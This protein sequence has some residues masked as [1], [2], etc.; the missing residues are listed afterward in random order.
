MTDAF[1]YDNMYSYEQRTRKKKKMSKEKMKKMKMKK[2][3]WDFE[4]MLLCEITKEEGVV[5]RV[6]FSIDKSERDKF[7]HLNNTDK[8][9]VKVLDGM[10]VE[11]AKKQTTDFKQHPFFMSKPNKKG[12]MSMSDKGFKQW[13]DYSEGRVGYL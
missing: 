13:Q 2:H 7:E 3:N 9:F 8:Y 10:T 11:M 6:V 5:K 4:T 12:H 1:K